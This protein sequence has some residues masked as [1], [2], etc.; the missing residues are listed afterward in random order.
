MG[1]K[2]IQRAYDPAPIFVA[3]VKREGL[4]APVQ[5]YQFAK[6]RRWRMDYAWPAHRVALEVEGGVWTGGRH[7]RA[8]GFLRDMEKYNEAALRGWKVLRTTPSELLSEET[9][10]LLVR[11]MAA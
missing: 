2:G 9:I 1:I 6:P 4:A 10:A 5:E 11:A 8:I 7:T 3:L